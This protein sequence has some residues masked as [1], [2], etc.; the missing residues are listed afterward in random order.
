MRILFCIALIL[1]AASPLSA[2]EVW[3]GVFEPRAQAVLPSEVAMPVASLPKKPGDLCRAGDVLVEFDAAV[4]Q[5]ALEA[6][7]MRLDAAELNYNGQQSLFERGQTSEVELAR[8]ASEL[9]RARL[10]AVTARRE[11][12]YCRVAAPFDGRIVDHRVREHEWAG[13]GA[14]LLL[15]IDDSVLTVRFFLP[16]ENFRNI[17]LGDGVR[18]RAPASGRTFGGVVS[19][20]GAAFDPA[21]RTFDVWAE[22]DNKEGLLRAG[23][24]AEV[25]WSPDA[26]SG[27]EDDAE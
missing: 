7:E 4:A 26:G 21:S 22:V 2:G 18:V 25:R 14:A 24:T 13:K 6:A 12:S 10:D 8:A 23:M 19:R 3:R 20:L 9:A 15:L 5:A 1:S 16:E 17:A 27:A 11:L